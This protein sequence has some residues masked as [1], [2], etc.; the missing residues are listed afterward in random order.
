MYLRYNYALDSHYRRWGNRK[1]GQNRHHDHEDVVDHFDNHLV[2]F[3]S[4]GLTLL[5]KMYHDRGKEYNE[6]VNKYGEPR[7]RRSDLFIPFEKCANRD[8]FLIPSHP[9]PPWKPR[10][11]WSDT[12]GLEMPSKGWVAKSPV[13]D[14]DGDGGDDD[15][16]DDDDDHHHHHHHHHH[17]DIDACWGE[18]WMRKIGYF[19]WDRD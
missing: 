19:I 3:T 4:Q 8:V 14:D 1:Y 15:D 17:H 7:Y 5:S 11:E 16:D 10:I 6:L 2:W 12:P 13:A 9:T 18:K